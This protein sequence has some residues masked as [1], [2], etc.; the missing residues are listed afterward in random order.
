MICIQSFIETLLYCMAPTKYNL[1]KVMLSVLSLSKHVPK[2]IRKTLEMQAQYVPRSTLKDF[3]NKIHESNAHEK[4]ILSLLANHGKRGKRLVYFRADNFQ[5]L[6]NATASASAKDATRDTAHVVFTSAIKSGDTMPE[7]D[8]VMM[9]DTMDKDLSKNTSIA[10][11]QYDININVGEPIFADNEIGPAP[12]LVKVTHPAFAP[13]GKYFDK[14]HLLPST[15]GHHS[16]SIKVPIARIGGCNFQE[17]DCEYQGE[18]GKKLRKILQGR[19][20]Y[21]TFLQ[22]KCPESTD[23]DSLTHVQRKGGKC[24]QHYIWTLQSTEHYSCRSR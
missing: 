19:L 7:D 3:M 14:V 17:P 24:A 11:K 12:N 21:E 22:H 15:D 20:E 5:R 1:P 16:H 6:Y 9:R 2:E 8:E 10:Y 18:L 4:C 13:N 23:M